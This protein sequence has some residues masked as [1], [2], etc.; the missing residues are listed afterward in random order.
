MPKARAPDFIR[1]RHRGTTL[2]TRHTSL[3]CWKE[4]YTSLSSNFWTRRK[5]LTISLGDGSSMC[6][7]YRS[8]SNFISCRERAEAP[9]E[10]RG[11]PPCLTS[12]AWRETPEKVVGE[13]KAAPPLRVSE[14]WPACLPTSRGHWEGVYCQLLIAR[15]ICPAGSETWGVKGLPH[16]PKRLHSSPEPHSE[17]SLI[18]GA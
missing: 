4:T 15:A 11:M 8:V 1:N 3:P 5:L 18:R 9:P 14:C 13:L 6:V 17:P 7:Q 10:G 12:E 16:L 2:P